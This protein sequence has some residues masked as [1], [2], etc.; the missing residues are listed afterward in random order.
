M[1]EVPHILS[2]FAPNFL[3]TNNYDQHNITGWFNQ[4]GGERLY[5]YGCGQG[6]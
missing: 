6:H 2:I 1:I 4:A 3:N 5:C